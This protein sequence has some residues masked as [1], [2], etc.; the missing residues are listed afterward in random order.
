MG[1]TCFLPHSW[2]MQIIKALT[3]KP[4]C[5]LHSNIYRQMC[6]RAP[7]KAS[8]KTFCNL[9]PMESASKTKCSCHA[10]TVLILVLHILSRPQLCTCCIAYNGLA[11]S[12]LDRSDQPRAVSTSADRSSVQ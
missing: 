9:K 12:L 10:K 7:V 11:V 5:S 8:V 3:G 4:V 2:E 1:V 6:R